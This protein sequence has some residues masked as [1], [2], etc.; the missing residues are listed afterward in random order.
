MAEQQTQNALTPD[1]TIE[2]TLATPEH[3]EPAP[4]P[5]RRRQQSPK[6]DATPK[7]TRTKKQ[8]AVAP[9][10]AAVSTNADAAT[11]APAPSPVISIQTDTRETEA[12]VAPVDTLTD[13][14]ETPLSP[15]VE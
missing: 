8:P 10:D 7:K 14:P 9:V 1:T 3:Q 11:E 13:I 12:D 5:T 15:V 6:N 4:K 2:D